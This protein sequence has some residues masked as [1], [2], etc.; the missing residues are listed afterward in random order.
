MR[1]LA[2]ACVAVA[3]ATVSW[4][5]LRRRWRRL[6]R[7]EATAARHR[8]KAERRRVKR[9]MQAPWSDEA[10]GLRVAIDIGMESL[11]SDGEL[12]S[13]ATQVMLS[14]AFVVKRCVAQNWRPLRLALTNTDAA[15][16]TLARIHNAASAEIG[17]A[18]PVE[19]VG[20]DFATGLPALCA[21]DA[22]QIVVLSP[23]A[24]T[25]LTTLDPGAIY[26]IG[27][28]VDHNRYK[29]LTHERAT[30]AGIETAR[31]PIDEHVQMSQRRVLAV[32][33]VFEILLHFAQG[34]DWKQAFLH[35]MPQ[36]RA[37]EARDEPSES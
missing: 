30:A 34:H 12:A 6:A 28:L 33:H 8:L 19:V 2:L 14:Y 27:G 35:A 10:G 4:L 16:A 5:T 9:L 23:D 25:P 36:R 1:R 21:S 3:T 31:L 37:A 7:W 22:P 32:N 24:E 29:G 26:V 11:M 17:D 20:S 13:L 18:W 15:A